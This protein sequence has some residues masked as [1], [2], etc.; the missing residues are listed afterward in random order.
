LYFLTTWAKDSYNRLCSLLREHEPDIAHFHNTLPLISSSAYYACVDNGVPVVQTLH[1]YRLIC[2]GAL[3][4][5]DGKVCE[6]CIGGDFR[7]AVRH[8]CYR[9]SYIQTRAVVRMLKKNRK[10]GTYENE[11]HS[12]IALTEFARGKYIQGGLSAD[13]IIVKPNFLPNP[14]ESRFG[15][16][17][18]LFIGR[19]SPEKGVNILLDAW[20]NIQFP[21]KLAGDGPQRRELENS[22]PHA[23]RFLGQ[24]TREEVFNLLAGARF[25]VLPSVCYE[26]F[27]GT[28]VEAF[29]CGK[30]VVAS[31]L[32]SAAEIV[33]NEKTGLHFQTG[34]AD[35]LAE[36][37]DRLIKDPD[38]AVELGRNARKEFEKKYTAKRN[39]E[40][41]I[42]IYE[43]AIE[44]L[45]N[46]KS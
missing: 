32:G 40:M 27:P 14:P 10:W 9:G 13:K 45:K 15:G 8:R 1:N 11:I 6:E 25:L 21:L 38:L 12:Y 16:D 22:A 23:A 39:H 44:N 7:P 19:I 30:P 24:V 28:I 34:N 43:M 17:Y 35:D 31:K 46:E 42:R 29:A 20:K 41:L 36:K 4:M 2:P 26:G 3:L 5:R 33:E 37:A 18:A